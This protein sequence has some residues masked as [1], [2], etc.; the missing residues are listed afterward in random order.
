MRRTV[1]LGGSWNRFNKAYRG[2]IAAL[3]GTREKDIISRDNK[4]KNSAVPHN[5]NK[6]SKHSSWTHKFVCLASTSQ[7]RVPS[8]ANKEDLLL[9]GLG[10]KKVVIPDVDC[11]IQDFH[12]VLLEAFPKLKDAG[13]F[14]LLRCM[15]NS[16]DLEEVPSPIN[17][18]PRL[19]RTHMSSA[20]LYLR[21]IQ[22]DL[23]LKP[24]IINSGTTVSILYFILLLY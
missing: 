2:A 13:G 22:V 10:E 24:N 7:E 6:M 12:D 4:R 5:F 18:S 23:D 15:P 14:E 3:R 9:A 19:L 11:T 16:R 21:P 17:L 8:S 20:R 1:F